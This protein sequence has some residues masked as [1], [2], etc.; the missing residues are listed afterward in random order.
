[1]KKLLF[2]TCLI[3]ALAFGAEMQYTSER[4]VINAKPGT[5]LLGNLSVA[6]PVTVLETKDGQ[7]KIRVEGWSLK[8][9]PSQIFS[10]PGVR[11]EYASFDEEDA[12]KLNTEEKPVVV[13]DNKWVKSSAEGW[14][15]SKDLTPDINA[16]WEQGKAREQQ[17][18]SVCHPAPHADH[19]TA[20]QWA[21]LLPLKGGR[22]GHTRA[23]ANALMFK[24]LQ[25]HAK[26]M[27]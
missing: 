10:T 21:S 27:Q 3:P 8:E 5:S 14:I 11:I 13:A 1:M 26:P 22:T 6:A 17:A 23:G 9:Y 20:N 18:C 7:S 4:A 2:L 19:F 16:L 24:Y 12:V 15:P 25:T